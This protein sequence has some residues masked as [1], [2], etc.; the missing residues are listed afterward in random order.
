[1]NAV[2]KAKASA[3]SLLFD[4]MGELGKELHALFFLDSLR[5]LAKFAASIGN[6]S[7]AA[8]VGVPSA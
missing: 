3:L 8:G 6:I 5:S 7:G 2:S 1:M 4:D